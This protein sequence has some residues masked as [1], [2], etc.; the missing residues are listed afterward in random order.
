MPSDVINRKCRQVITQKMKT[1]DCLM[2]TE[3]GSQNEIKDRYIQQILASSVNVP[4]IK[5]KNNMVLLMKNLQDRTTKRVDGAKSDTVIYPAYHSHK[6]LQKIEQKEI[7]FKKIQRMKELASR[8]KS[9][10]RR[11]SQTQYDFNR[12]KVAGGRDSSQ[13]SML[14][15]KMSSTIE[16]V[17]FN[18]PGKV[19]QMTSAR[20]SFDINTGKNTQKTSQIDC[21][22][23]QYRKTF[24]NTSNMEKI[25]NK[26]KK[27]PKKKPFRVVAGLKLTMNN[28]S[29][30]ISKIDEDKLRETILNKPLSI[31]QLGQFAGSS[32]PDTAKKSEGLSSGLK[33]PDKQMLPTIQP[34]LTSEQPN[35]NYAE[36]IQR[37]KKRSKKLNNR[38]SR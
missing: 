30:D 32:K 15:D 37:K 31:R 36:E 23:P 24:D 5:V 38:I 7:N 17:T 27:S 18:M 3:S 6:L 35:E 8:H 20:C 9:L 29:V 22:S 14:D 13:I 2:Q 4:K 16:Q 10:S 12:I 28:H 11:R 1:I 34:K 25:Q 19:S 33:T 26:F 21:D